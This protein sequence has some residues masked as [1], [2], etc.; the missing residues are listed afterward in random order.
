MLLDCANGATYRA[1]P[2][3]FERLGAEVD[4]IACEPDGVNIN[5]GCGSTHMELIAER[6]REGGHDARLRLRR[7]RRPRARRRAATAASSTATRSS[8]QIALDLKRRGELPG[9]GVAVTVMTNFGFHNAME[10]AGIEVATTDVGD[11]HVVEE[12]VRR[13]WVLGGEQSGHIVDMRLTPSGDGIAA[14]LL[15]LRRSA[16]GRSS[17][18]LAM[19][20]SRRCS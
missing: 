12:L 8:P 16:S 1:A 5:A 14:A 2:L 17:A 3:L 6:M 18:V 13:G 15:L 11:R 9:N 4:A 7:R 19:R 20:S 10:E